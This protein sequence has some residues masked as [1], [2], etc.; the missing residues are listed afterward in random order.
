MLEVPE[1][2]KLK[3]KISTLKVTDRDQ[4]QNKEPIITILGDSSRVFAVELSPEKD[5]NLILKQVQ[6]FGL[7]V[8]NCASCLHLVSQ[9]LV[10]V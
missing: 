9:H 10:P 8:G 1:N 2:H 5:G 7:K 3:E 6:C 4:T